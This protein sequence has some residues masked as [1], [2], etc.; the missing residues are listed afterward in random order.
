VLVAV[1]ARVCQLLDP[2]LHLV[3]GHL[4]NSQSLSLRIRRKD[5]KE[6]WSNLL[7][8]LSEVVQMHKFFNTQSKKQTKS[9]KGFEIYIKEEEQM[10]KTRISTMLSVSKVIP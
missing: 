4:A 10:L 6:K 2:T 5:C 3:R 1:V 7:S 8:K 9:A